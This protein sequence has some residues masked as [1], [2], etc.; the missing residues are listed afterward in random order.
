MLTPGSQI[1]FSQLYPQPAAAFILPASVFQ[2]ANHNT[3]NGIFYVLYGSSTLF[4][5]NS[6]HHNRTDR[7]SEF[8]RHTKSNVVSYVLSVKVGRATNFL[9]FAEHIIIAFQLQAN[10]ERVH[11][12]VGYNVT[13]VWFHADNSIDL[14]MY[15]SSLVYRD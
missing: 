8:V 6:K 7:S 1:N 4:P 14:Y 13:L 9:N 11:K 12:L 15:A 10:K 2:L 3:E 5:V